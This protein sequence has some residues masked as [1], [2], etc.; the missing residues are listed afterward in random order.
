MVSSPNQNQK[1]KIITV[2]TLKVLNIYLELNYV[3]YI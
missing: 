1:K 3:N 2:R